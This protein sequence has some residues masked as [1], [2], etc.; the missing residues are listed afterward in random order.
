MSA[1]YVVQSVLEML[2]A[3]TATRSPSPY[4][5]FPNTLLGRFTTIPKDPTSTSHFKV[6]LK[7]SHN[8]ESQNSHSSID[9]TTCKHDFGDSGL[10]GYWSAGSH[11]FATK[12]YCLL[13]GCSLVQSEIYINQGCRVWLRQPGGLEAHNQVARIH[14]SRP[15]DN[16]MIQLIFKRSLTG[17]SLTRFRL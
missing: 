10:S 11:L 4:L 13:D 15:S 1:E 5:S 14:Q 3:S 2:K 16:K 12:Q 17:N 9:S 8:G 6:S 7:D